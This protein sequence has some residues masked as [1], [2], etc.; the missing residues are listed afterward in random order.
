[1][2]SFIKGMLFGAG[3]G[4]LVAPMRGEEMRNLLNERLKGLQEYLPE[5]DQWN[6][7]TR[8]VSERVSQTAGNL[9][10]YAQQAASTMKSA[11]GNIS[12]LA[13]KSPSD[14]KQTGQ[15]VSK[16]TKQNVR[17]TLAK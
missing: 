13:Q 4:L 11:T 17:S 16:T 6:T 2:N 12:D 3:I 10:D 14:I 1:M 15:D 5:S 9:K 7:Y 8:Q